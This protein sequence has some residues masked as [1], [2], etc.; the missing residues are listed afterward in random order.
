VDRVLGIPA[1]RKLQDRVGVGESES[2]AA[3]ISGDGRNGFGGIVLCRWD[4]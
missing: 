1:S 3:G 2:N 4:G